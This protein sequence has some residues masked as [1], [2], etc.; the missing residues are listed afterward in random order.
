MQNVSIQKASELPQAVKSAV[1]QL[2][3]R[4]IAP[5]EELALLPFLRNRFHLRQAGPQWHGI[6]KRSSISV[7]TKL[8]V[9]RKKKPMR[10]T[11]PEW[12]SSTVNISRSTRTHSVPY[13]YRTIRQPPLR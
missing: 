9:F 12:C 11:Q 7:R 1:E 8:T 5:D 6:W 3:D 2:L 10:T 13:E 4:S